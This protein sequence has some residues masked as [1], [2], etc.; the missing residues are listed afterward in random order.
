MHVGFAFKLKNGFISHIIATAG[1]I[2]ASHFK[3]LASK[4]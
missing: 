3:N 4:E 2:N 1:Q